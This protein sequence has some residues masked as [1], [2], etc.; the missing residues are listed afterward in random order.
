MCTCL[1][2]CL[3]VCVCVPLFLSTAHL[4]AVHYD[5]VDG[6]Q[7]RVWLGAVSAVEDTAAVDVGLVIKMAQKGLTAVQK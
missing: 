5:V 6:C 3:I 2:V 7:V 1:Y 4:P